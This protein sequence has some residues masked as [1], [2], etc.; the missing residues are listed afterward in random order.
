MHHEYD[1]TVANAGREIR[2]GLG[3]EYYLLVP[4]HEA[5]NLLLALSFRTDVILHM[6]GYTHILV[7]W[8]DDQT[9]L[10]IHYRVGDELVGEVQ[11]TAQE[12]EYIFKGLRRLFR[13]LIADIP[14]VT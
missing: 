6:F 14:R 10:R 4:A 9:N 2:I 13:Q 7:M 11:L 12:T 1:L 5:W 8:S 3:E